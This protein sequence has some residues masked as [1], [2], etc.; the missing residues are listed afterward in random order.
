MF[1]NLDSEAK[2]VFKHYSSLC[3]C[4]MTEVECDCKC[5]E[6]I[7]KFDNLLKGIKCIYSAIL[8]CPKESLYKVSIYTR[9]NKDKPILIMEGY[10]SEIYKEYLKSYP[11]AEQINS[12]KLL[13]FVNNVYRKVHG[14]T[15]INTNN[16]SISEIDNIN[17]EDWY[18]KSVN[19]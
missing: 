5:V 8:Y 18:I 16:K 1:S 17:A 4:P 7:H 9:K 10:I 19:K 13:N 2:I 6:K 12:S 3:K 14:K 11:K 15:L